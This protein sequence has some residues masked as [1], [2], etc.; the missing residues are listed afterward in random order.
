[1]EAMRREIDAHENDKH[2]PLVRRRKLNGK[3]TIMYKCSFKRNR[4]P[5]GR[6]IKH[7][8]RL[9]PCMHA[10]MGVNYWGN[11]STMVNM[12]SGRSMI[13]LSIL[14]YI[15]TESVNFVLVY[16]QTNEKSDIFMELPIGFGV[17]GSH[18]R[19]WVI[20]LD[21]HLWSKEYRPGMV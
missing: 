6:L 12:M 15:H 17:E 8:A 9:R 18:P 16:N 20:R 19:E 4:A 3:K 1:M 2:W 5:Y 13:T 7:K 14:R 10:E 21:N 11:Y